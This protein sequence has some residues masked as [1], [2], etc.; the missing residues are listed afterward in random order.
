MAGRI[1]FIAVSV[2]C[3]LF[4]LGC[5]P[6]SEPAPPAGKDSPRI[7][8]IG[9]TPDSPPLIYRSGGKITGLEAELAREFAAFAGRNL[10]FVEVGWVDQI[11]ALLSGKTDIIM[12]GMTVTD[13][14]KI[15]INFTRPYLVTG[16]SS[17]VRMDDY[18][19]FSS[20]LTDL[21]NPV[22]TIGTVRGTT[23]DYLVRQKI[24][25]STIRRFDK[26][27]EGV[28]ALLEEKIDVFVYDMPM[29]FYFAARYEARG[30]IPVTVPLSREYIAWG[31]RREDRELLDTAN[32]FL[33]EMRDQDRLQAI[34]RKW[35]PF[36]GEVFG[37]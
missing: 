32:R 12:S 14:R 30:I 22:V 16:Q 9:I 18:S 26:P 20:G 37:P 31:V 17:L 13:L 29:N 1:L 21:L 33:K 11:P 4:F 3:I 24:G 34:V 7:L 10:R 19:R 2:L 28:E 35:I 36:H 8:K 27:R 15:R 25:S 6:K 23:G 5:A